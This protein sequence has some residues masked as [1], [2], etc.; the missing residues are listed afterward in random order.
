[1]PIEQVKA[2]FPTSLGVKEILYVSLG[3]KFLLIPREGI[4]NAD[5]QLYASLPTSV[6][7]TGESFLTLI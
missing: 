6:M 4:L 3:C 2:I 7:V 1:M 5:A